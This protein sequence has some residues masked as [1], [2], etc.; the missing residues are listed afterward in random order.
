MWQNVGRS[1]KTFAGYE[2]EFFSAEL[3][4]KMD[5][6][7]FFF[8]QTFVARVVNHEVGVSEQSDTKLRQWL[9]ATRTC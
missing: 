1:V 9:T 6:S 8:Q 5:F 2:T 3:R 4:E 7:Y